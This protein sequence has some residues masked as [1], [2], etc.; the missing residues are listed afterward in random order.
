MA[1][2]TTRR[3]DSVR[4]QES[5]AATRAAIIEAATRLF[6]ERGWGG[7]SMKDIAAAARVS[8]ETIYASVGNKNALLKLAFDVGVVGDD[9]PLRLIE[10]PEFAALSE[11][12]VA[13]R[14]G[15][16]GRLLAEMYGRIGPLHRALDHAAAGDPD[17]RAYASRMRAD[18]HQS[19]VHGATAV[20]GREVSEHE[21]Q[22][23]VACLGNEAFLLL[24]GQYGWTEEKY[25]T[26]VAQTAVRLL[27][28]REE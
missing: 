12:G 18:I 26:W 5:A 8:V 27:G 7:T 4:R 6:A 2:T 23:L 11:G 17:L 21:V 16:L 9:E 1:S 13:D 3:Y 20:A 15:A 14:A 28:L 10:R 25:A 19:F 24:T 22:T